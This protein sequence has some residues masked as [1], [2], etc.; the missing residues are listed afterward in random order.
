MIIKLLPFI[1]CTIFTHNLFGQN[2]N[3]SFN[4][5]YLTIQDGLSSN[6]INSIIQDKKGFL[7]IGTE[8][9]LNRYDGYTFKV[10]RNKR[11][12][13]N[14]LSNNFIWSL[15]EDKDGMIWIGT[16]GGGLNKFNPV[17]EKFE[18][19]VYDNK[20]N[21]SLS[22]DIV[23]NVF[24][25]S[26]NNLWISTWG[27][28]LNLFDRKT[29]SFKR[30][31]YNPGEEKSI[32][33]DK[34]FFVFEDS[35]SR[36]WVGTDEGGLNLFAD[37]TQ[38]F[39]KYK[40]DP[41]DKNSISFNNLTT[42]IELAD[43]S[44]LIGTSGGGLNRFFYEQNKF[45]K[46]NTGDFKNIWK[47]F[48]D[49]SS[50]VW[51]GSS[52]GEGVCVLSLE[53][54]ELTNLKSDKSKPSSLS[55]NDI[56]TIFEDNTNV[57][58]IGTAAGGLNKIDRKPKK[59]LQINQSNSA[60]PDNFVFTLEEDKNNDIWIGTYNKGI[61]RFNPK[62]KTFQNY[63]PSV[64]QSGNLHGEIVR[65]LY[66]DN[67]NNL[68]VGTY[69]G[70]LNKYN[71][72]SD[73]FGYLNLDVSNNNPSANLIR[74]IYEDSEGLLWFGAIGG[75]GLTSFNQVTNEFKF[76]STL[77]NNKST[78]SGNDI[79]S[80]CEDKNG[81]LWFG[82]YSF[83]LN[84]YDKNTNTFKHFLREENNSSS[85]PDNIITDIFKDS[86]DNLWIS[87]Y[88]GGLCKYNY[89]HNNFE[90]FSEDDG[91]ASNSI[92]GILEDD[93]RNLWLSTSR[94]ITKFNYKSYVSRNYD[95]TDG[96]QPPE[97]NPSA[98]L[99]T[100]HGYMYFG[101]VEGLT[102][103]HPDSVI[104][105]SYSSNVSITS[106]KLF[107]EE[108]NLSAS[109]TFTD[110]ITLEYNENVFSFE[111]ASL[112]FTSPEKN[113]Y[114][115]MLEGFDPDWVNTGSRRF[116]N[117]THLDPGEYVFKVKA[118]NSTGNWSQ[119][120]SIILIIKPPFWMTWW[121]RTILLVAFLSIG[122]MIYYRRVNQLKK[123]KSIQVEFSKQL[124]QSQENERK[125]I[126]SELHDSLGQELL[127]IKNLALLNKNKD[128]Q[129]E[130]ISKTAG[131]ALDEVRRI[132]YN[133]HPYQ[134]D[135]LGLTKAIASMFVNIEGASGIK[136]DLSIDNVDGLFDK[137]KEINI[138]RI[139]QECVT[140]II[141]HS[142]ANNAQVI[143]ENAEDV[144]LI[145]IADDGKGFD[146]ESAK[147]ESKGFGLKNL[148]SR[149]SFLGG[150][151]EFKSDEESKTQIKFKI[152]FGK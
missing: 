42:M 50:D 141:K 75:G 96:I 133:L 60:L 22:S 49:K 122:P 80:I 102:F 44:F 1:F 107:N 68:W 11:G 17:T 135:R 87:T 18:R 16:D 45:E 146:F 57:L 124:I 59:F 103:F 29:N 43:N 120:A 125:R 48:Q 8:D 123:E 77:Q 2:N 106:F 84:R 9:G 5:I 112:D 142:D 79:T 144:L 90:I 15:C 52:V 99:K 61:T 100:K 86:K 71:S 30:F 111:F 105:E 4:F 139:I 129:F 47:V 70:E 113:C 118:T 92:Y 137:E 126:A 10:Y 117:Y 119:P 95:Q 121:F 12:D 26:K 76:Y 39:I 134:L 41:A 55:S 6:S 91:F 74:I 143:V 138:F 136:F 72:V 73:K 40:H 24:T 82:T 23:Q 28:G 66:N 64:N 56:R 140:N 132:S 131:Q 152:P 115:Y 109:I 20:N 81:N 38:S 19:F 147:S 88:S 114:A 89:E 27:G 94:G 97:F 7:W 145:E 110:S 14:S 63:F 130:E 128:D 98:R 21:I 46:I 35:K 149:V 53:K 85:L 116:V 33:S 13:K 150:R 25:D 51:C 108:K 104:E 58:W 69:Y 65:Y 31:R 101:G 54:N 36:I 34:I 32:G 148:D 62:N 67:K 78:I 93:Q 37:K 127:V 83:G 151:L 3:S